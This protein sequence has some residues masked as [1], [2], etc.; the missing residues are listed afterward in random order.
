MN[1]W[2]AP[3]ISEH[4]TYRISGRLIENLAWFRRPGR[5]TMKDNTLGTRFLGTSVFPQSLAANR[6]ARH[7]KAQLL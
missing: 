4:C 7:D 5:V 1:L 3:Q 2:F 6:S